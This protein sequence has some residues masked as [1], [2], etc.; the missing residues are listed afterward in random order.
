MTVTFGNQPIPLGSLRIC[1]Y[2]DTTGDGLT[3]D[4]VLETSQV[5]YYEVNHDDGLINTVVNTGPSGCVTLDDL[6][7]G[8]YTITEITPL[9]D[10]WQCTTPGG[11]PPFELHATV[12]VN[13]LVEV[14]FA[15]YRESCQPG[16]RTIGFYKNHQCVVEQVLPITIAG[17]EITDAERA[18]EIIEDRDDHWSRL[19]SQLMA[20]K[21]NVAVF[22]IGNCSLEQLGLEGGE[23]V[24][25]IIAQAEDLLAN[26]DATNDQLSDMQDLLELINSSNTD[27]PLPEEIE[28]ACPTDE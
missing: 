27:T 4:D 12:S 9:P 26:P 3:G 1:K 7:V 25:D 13:T 14:K 6:P 8:S 22:G 16:S 2:E 11:A 17:E 21:L 10:G 5:W 19:R 24:N 18:I 23:T 20:T 15:N 28:E